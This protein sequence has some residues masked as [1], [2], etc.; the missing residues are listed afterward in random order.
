MVHARV[1]GRLDALLTARDLEDGDEDDIAQTLHW[2]IALLQ[3]LGLKEQRWA[4]SLTKRGAELARASASRGVGVEEYPRVVRTMM[5]E[6]RQLTKQLASRAPN[7]EAELGAVEQ[8]LGS[9]K[10]LQA[11]H[12]R[13]LL[14]LEALAE[15]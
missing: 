5:P 10:K 6:L 8:S 14:R 13:L 12:R 4:K 3:R 9:P 7:L 11:A 2:Q 1:L 15:R